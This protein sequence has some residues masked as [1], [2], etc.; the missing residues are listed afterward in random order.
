MFVVIQYHEKY[1][2]KITF[3]VMNFFNEIVV[4]LFFK[5]SE[6]LGSI[7]SMYTLYLDGQC[8]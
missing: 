1:K 6:I 4:N 7:L 8:D 5:L 2:M 3:L